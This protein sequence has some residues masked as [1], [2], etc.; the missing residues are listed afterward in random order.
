MRTHDFTN[1]VASFKNKRILVVGDVMLDHYSY[2]K[3]TR[4]SPEAPVPIIQIVEERFVPG[5]AGNVFQNLCEYGV[6]A[7]LLAIVGND[8]AAKKLKQSCTISSCG[9]TLFIIDENRRTTVKHRLVAHRQQL[10]RVDTEDTAPIAS[11]LESEIVAY[12]EEHIGTFD[13]LCIA[14][15]AKG[16]ITES[17][18]SKLT[19]ICAEHEIPI[20]VDTKPAHFSF[21]RDCTMLTPNEG[22]VLAAY[23]NHTYQEAAKALFAATNTPVLVTRGKEGVAYVTASGEE[24]ALPSYANEEDV[25][26]VSGAGDTVVATLALALSCGLPAHDAAF[27]A[28]KAAAIAITKPQTSAVTLSELI[29]TL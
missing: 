22:E 5:G 29:E 1:I 26:D 15:Y 2:G 27:I 16:G 11:T 23:P 12:V 8:E 17:V 25:R 7:V 24:F 3:V 6:Q 13:C 19:D 20:L 21:Y 4:I 18:A 10:L 14:D 28:S 9:E